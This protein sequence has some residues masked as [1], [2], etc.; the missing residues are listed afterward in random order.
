[1]A[2]ADTL[3]VDVKI[4]GVNIDDQKEV[5]FMERLNDLISEY[6]FDGFGAEGEADKYNENTKITIRQSRSYF[7]KS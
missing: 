3:T 7:K 6:G 4:A 1:M 2:F 5:E